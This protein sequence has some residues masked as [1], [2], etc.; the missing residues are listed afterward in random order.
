ME[1]SF[2]TA[3]LDEL[4]KT[5]NQIANNPE[6]LEVDK[7][8]VKRCGDYTKPVMQKEIP[9]SRDNS[10]S[11]RRLKGGGTSRP[12]HGH[13]ADNIPMSRPTIKDGAAKVEIGW[14]LSD[15]SEYFYMKFVNW[16]TA[17]RPPNPFI[18]RAVKKSENEYVEIATEE[19]QD[20]IKTKMGD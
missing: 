8:I 13:A 16:G 5:M 11:G 12:Q 17:S 9:R 3:N 1:I 6:R 14:K 18:T 20:F 10:K 15:N 4:I 2:D 7:K 19:Y